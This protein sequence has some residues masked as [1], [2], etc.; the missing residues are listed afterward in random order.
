MGGNFY[1]FREDSEE[2]VLGKQIIGSI[3]S[4]RVFFLSSDF[5]LIVCPENL[6]F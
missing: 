1:Q 5:Q 4:P 3:F 2:S 6:V